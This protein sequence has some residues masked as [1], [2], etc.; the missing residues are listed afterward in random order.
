ML[1]VE[2]APLRASCWA[3]HSVS[4]CNI[5][6]G[7]RGQCTASPP[8]SSCFLMLP[9]NFPDE[10]CGWLLINSDKRLGPDLGHPSW[11]IQFLLLIWLRFKTQNA[12]ERSEGNLRD[13]GCASYTDI[14]KG[15]FFAKG[16]LRRRL[17]RPSSEG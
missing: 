11:R 17:A 3:V 7:P 15:S 5:Q 10:S 1:D 14:Q 2:A 13:S 4:S 6:Q 9:M 8:A 16:G 12:L